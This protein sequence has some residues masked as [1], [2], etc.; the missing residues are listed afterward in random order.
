MRGADRV[1]RELAFDP[2]ADARTTPRR[3]RQGPADCTGRFR[4]S[5]E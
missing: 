4:Q 2:R 5:G 1:E 3:S